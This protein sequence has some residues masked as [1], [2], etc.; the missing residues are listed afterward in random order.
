M[1]V[2]V[3]VLIWIRI[4][5]CKQP[6]KETEILSS[7]CSV[8]CCV[9]THPRA[10]VLLGSF[11]QDVSGPK[12]HILNPEHATRDSR[13]LSPEITPSITIIDHSKQALVALKT[14]LGAS[15]LGFRE[16]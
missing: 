12:L 15:G 5:V 10:K 2:C 9:P 3:C 6:R 14:D 8:Q 4:L 11:V 7:C 13:T 16:F 1:C